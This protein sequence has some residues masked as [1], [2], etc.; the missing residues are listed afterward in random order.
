MKLTTNLDMLIQVDSMS[1]DDSASLMRTKLLSNKDDEVHAS[2]LAQELEYIPLAI[3][4]ACSYI[5]Q[6][7]P[8]MSVRQY[9]EL[10][11]RSA[12]HQQFLLDF[13][14]ENMRREG[15][16]QVSVLTSWEISFLQIKRDY[17]QS[18]DLL[19]LMSFF[20]R[21]AI[22]RFLI[23]DAGDDLLFLSTLRPLLAFSL[24]KPDIEDQTFSLHSLVQTA[25]R[26]WLSRDNSDQAW[27][28][29]A[30]ELLMRWFPRANQIYAAKPTCDALLL[31]TE[32][33]LQDSPITAPSQLNWANLML[34]TT[35]YINER[36]ADHLTAE[37][38]AR[39]LLSILPQ[40]YPED[41]DEIL[42][43]NSTLWAALLFQGRLQEALEF[44]E[45]AYAIHLD[46][47]DFTKEPAISASHNVAFTHLELGNYQR[48]ED[49]LAPV[50]ASGHVAK[51]AGEVSQILSTILLADVKLALR[52]LPEAEGLYAEALGAIAAIVG[53]RHPYT[54]HARLGLTAAY[55][56][57]GEVGKEDGALKEVMDMVGEILGV[58]HPGCLDV[59]G[60]GGVP[61]RLRE[62]VERGERLCERCVGVVVDAS[63]RGLLRLLRILGLV[64]EV[65]DIEV[66]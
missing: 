13:K 7:S 40:F 56:A 14:P 19:S 66:E 12:K 21:Q 36:K 52:K 60:C 24:I 30:T 5:E 53:E 2:E 20:N 11:R 28:E 37:T 43:A 25:T 35:W 50:F 46:N 22:P 59:R 55:R 3:T 65:D 48:A 23:Q 51:A 1:P 4:Q 15:D 49:L 29:K 44:Q 42:L 32:E 39:T 57:M 62:R 41:S 17:P 27:K 63:S 18:A 61:E 26:H 10:F 16:A 8:M 33:L 58:G 9:L 64:G 54:L 34:S 38:R 45:R 31:H 6:L 47:P